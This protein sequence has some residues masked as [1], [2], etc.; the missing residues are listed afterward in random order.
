MKQLTK[1]FGTIA[2]TIVLIGINNNSALADLML[3]DLPTKVVT[4]DLI[5]RIKVISS[6]GDSGPT[7][8]RGVV[9]CLVVESAKGLNKG[10]QF[11]LEFYNGMRSPNVRYKTGEDCLLFA[12]I[13]S[14]GRY[15]TFNTRDGKYAVK[16]SNVFGWNAPDRERK[17][18]KL[19]E[20][21]GTIRDLVD[22]PE[23][24]SKPIKG[25][26]VLLRPTYLNY[27]EEQ[28]VDVV[29]FFKNT[30]RETISIPYRGYPIDAMTYWSLNVRHGNNR[31]I[32]PTAHPHLTLKDIDNYAQKNTKEYSIKV[33]PG[34]ISSRVLY[35]INSAE[36]G[37]G[38]KEN[39]NYS[40]YAM[41][42]PG[43]YMIS[44][45]GH[46]MLQGEVLKAKPIKIVI[47][48]NDNR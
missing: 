17:N 16:D 34:K 26:S 37:W 33:A 27:E 4:C 28:N 42:T 38:A 14:N 1:R 13:L 41:D 19:V 44:G 20:V 40:Y 10:V 6:E 45:E 12:T 8:L 47:H 39:L 46:N 11:D 22:I 9:K 36:Q 35:R 24:W 18:C 25:I 30:S 3:I 32:N 21:M 48:N 7:G 23:D 43:V 29:V 2:L 31:I 15:R 5:A